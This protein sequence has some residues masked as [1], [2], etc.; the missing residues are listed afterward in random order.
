MKLDRV[1][2]GRNSRD[3]AGRKCEGTKRYT[4]RHQH[5]GRQAAVVCGD[6]AERLSNYGSG[7]RSVRG[8]ALGPRRGCALAP[9]SKVK[10]FPYNEPLCRIC[11]QARG[12]CHADALVQVSNQK[13]DLAAELRSSSRLVVQLENAGSEHSIE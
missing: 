7:L 3:R 4:S 11:W 13:G 9:P 5:A 2:G 1:Y 8:S 10:A 12:D 6:P